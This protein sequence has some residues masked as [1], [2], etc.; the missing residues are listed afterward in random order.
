[1]SIAFALPVLTLP[2]AFFRAFPLVRLMRGGHY[3]LHDELVPCCTVFRYLTIYW[4]SYVPVMM[5]VS[6]W[7]RLTTEPSFFMALYLVILLRSLKNFP[8]LLLPRILSSSSLYL[9]RC[10]A[11]NSSSFSCCLVTACLFCCST[12]FVGSVPS[13][14]TYC[15]AFM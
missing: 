11:S 9:C 12:L 2:I 13:C 6:V 5:L 4:S 8:S 15:I 3:A 14:I 10:L 7:T 1:M